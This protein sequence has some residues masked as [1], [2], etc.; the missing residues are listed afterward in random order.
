MAAKTK[1]KRKQKGASL[2]E[3]VSAMLGA[4]IVLGILILIGLD[5]IASDPGQPP[6]LRVTPTKLASTDG[7]HVVEVKV[8]NLT[9]Q[10]AAAVNVEGQL[11]RG[12]AAVETSSATLGYVP[13]GS[14]RRAGLI[15]T[16]DPK[17]FALEV[18]AT[19]YEEP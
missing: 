12:G 18:R 16:R 9:S 3:W 5:A 17:D 11:K 15:F 8:E 13:G 1:D 2:L 4:L 10:A 6:I 7:I 19:G 14:A